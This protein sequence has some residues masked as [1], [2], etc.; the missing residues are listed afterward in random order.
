M[1]TTLVNTHPHENK[2]ISDLKHIIGHLQGLVYRDHT[3]WTD[4]HTPEIMIIAD[5]LTK[6][7]DELVGLVNNSIETEWRK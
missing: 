1:T 5:K 2:M 3:K 7:K 4:L 6:I